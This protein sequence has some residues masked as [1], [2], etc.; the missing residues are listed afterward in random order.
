MKVAPTRYKNVIS[1]V[2]WLN[3]LIEIGQTSQVK[4][5]VDFEEKTVLM[6]LSVCS[7]QRMKFEKNILWKKL[8]IWIDD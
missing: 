4:H 7:L 1:T 6:K 8:S 5:L 3:S 2:L